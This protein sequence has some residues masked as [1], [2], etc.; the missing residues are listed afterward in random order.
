MLTKHCFEERP[1]ARTAPDSD[2]LDLSWVELRDA[3]THANIPAQA[4]KAARLLHKV[5]RLESVWNRRRLAPERCTTLS[6][7]C[8][9]WHDRKMHAQCFQQRYEQSQPLL[10]FIRKD[11]ALQA[12]LCLSHPIHHQQSSDLLEKAESVQ[13]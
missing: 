5:R 10:E 6:G 12:R 7:T 11:T 9:E 1:A 2:F 8:L 13:P 4:T 3:V